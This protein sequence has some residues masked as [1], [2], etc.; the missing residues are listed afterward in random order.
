M[1]RIAQDE[2]ILQERAERLLNSIEYARAETEKKAANLSPVFAQSAE[3]LMSLIT[4]IADRLHKSRRPKIETLNNYLS[5]LHNTYE[6]DLVHF[7][8]ESFEKDVRRLQDLTD[9]TYFHAPAGSFKD[10]A[11]AELRV[12]KALRD[13]IEAS[14][15]HA[16]GTGRLDG[17][18]PQI[19]E[20]FLNKAQQFVGEN[21]G[22]VL[23][24]APKS[25]K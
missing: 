13:A 20:L 18:E 9:V 6:G 8:A 12:E 2:A 22:V 16:Q 21:K 10:R 1:K 17:I 3:S 23:S 4:S 19:V 5:Q 15:L 14:F 24:F 7:P 25:P 11:M